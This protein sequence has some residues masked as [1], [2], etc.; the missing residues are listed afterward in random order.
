MMHEGMQNNPGIIGLSVIVNQSVHLNLSEGDIQKFSLMI[1][2]KLKNNVL[3]R[4]CI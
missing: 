1:K 3:L 2:D 4:D